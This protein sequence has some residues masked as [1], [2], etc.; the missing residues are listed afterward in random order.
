[1]VCEKENEDENERG[2]WI[3]YIDYLKTLNLM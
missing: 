1:M 2:L 3:I